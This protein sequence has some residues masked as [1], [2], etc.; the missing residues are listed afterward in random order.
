MNFIKLFLGEFDT[1]NVLLLIAGLIVFLFIYKVHFLP[2]KRYKNTIIE[3]K[4]VI[5]EK[6]LK[7]H[8]LAEQLKK[9]KTDL[10]TAELNLELCNLKDEA[11]SDSNTTIK[12]TSDEGYLIF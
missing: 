7:I 4:Q 6:D 11:Y 3:Y 12:D 10:K 8:N 5:D 1:K 2:I 9:L